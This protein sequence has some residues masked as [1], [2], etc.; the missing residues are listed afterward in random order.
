MAVTVRE[1]TRDQLAQL[2]QAYI[3]ELLADPSWGDLADAQDL[4]NDIIFEHYDGIEFVD[5]DFT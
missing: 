4:P 1:L 5:D 3:C 2:K